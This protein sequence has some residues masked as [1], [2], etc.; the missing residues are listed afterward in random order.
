MNNNLETHDYRPALRSSYKSMIAIIVIFIAACVFSFAGPLKNNASNLMWMWIICLIAIVALG[1]YM[2]AQTLGAVLSIRAD[3]VAFDTGILNRNSTEISYKNLRT[4]NVKQTFAQRIFNVG[5]IAIASSG[6][7][8]Y[9]IKV[10]NMPDPYAIRDEIQAHERAP[11]NNPP[12]EP[13]PEN[14]EEK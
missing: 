9:E 13:K 14:L 6:T 4:V 11:R 5:D 2:K 1:V 3:E 10:P 8:G 12:E 7:D